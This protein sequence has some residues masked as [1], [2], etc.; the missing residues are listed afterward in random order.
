MKLAKRG[1][2]NQNIVVTLSGRG[3]KD[4]GI[5]LSYLKREHPSK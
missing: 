3:D 1:D 2:K 5:V 4:L